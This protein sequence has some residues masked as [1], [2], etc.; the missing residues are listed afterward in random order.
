MVNQ[1]R[2]L[3]LQSARAE[4]IYQF[5]NLFSHTATLIPA[6]LTIFKDNSKLGRECSRLALSSRRRR[7]AVFSDRIDRRDS[8]EFLKVTRAFPLPRVSWNVS[9]FHD[10]KKF[11]SVARNNWLKTYSYGI[12][13]TLNNEIFSERFGKQKTIKKT[14]CRSRMKICNLRKSNR[15]VIDDSESREKTAVAYFFA[16][17]SRNVHPANALMVHLRY[18]C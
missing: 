2:N 8:R 14:N 15:S 4:S 6:S 1:S 10:T 3:L 9:Q 16:K 17:L 7:E 11:W 5:S 18:E 12:R 13:E